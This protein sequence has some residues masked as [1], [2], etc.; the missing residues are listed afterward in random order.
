MQGKMQ[1]EVPRDRD[2]GFKRGY[3]EIIG[4]DKRVGSVPVKCNCDGIS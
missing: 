1:P 2:S 3:D 4:V